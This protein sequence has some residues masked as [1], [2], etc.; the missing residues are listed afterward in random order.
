MNS[1]NPSITTLT[2][3]NKP[4]IYIEARNVVASFYLPSNSLTQ[5]A[6]IKKFSGQAKSAI[7]AEAINMLYEK[8]V[9]ENHLKLVAAT[10]GIML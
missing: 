4:L 6:L 7:V 10:Q 8:H 1:L 3:T 9:K 5:I 2:K